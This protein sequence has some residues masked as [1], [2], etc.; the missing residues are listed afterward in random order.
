MHWYS[1]NLN[2][3]RR[4]KLFL[5]QEYSNYSRFYIN[6]ISPS[7]E[8]IN[9][10]EIRVAGL[11]RTGNHAIIGWIRSQHPAKSWHLNHPPAGK[12]PYQYL[13]AHYKKPH[14]RQEAIG[15]FE[16]KSLLIISYEDQPLDQIC[17][18]KFEKFH[19]VYVGL[20]E[21][22]FNVLILRDPFNLL[23]SRLKSK[24]SSLD[25]D[26]AYNALQ[27]W[28]AYAREFLNETQLLK[29][30]KICI[31]Y[32]QW[33]LDKPYRQELAKSMDLVFTD[34]GRERVRGY[35]GGSSFDGRNLDG[36]ASQLDILNRWQAFEDVSQFWQLF[37][38]EE[39]LHYAKS[40]FGTASLPFDRI[41][42]VA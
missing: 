25:D 14:L 7:K 29:G 26:S 3:L 27:L 2:Y 40:I 30:N 4:K 22:C 18:P 12:N 17:S 8:V 16:K 33:H 31:N 1:N 28:K 34:S 39:L 24:M 32:S 6:A 15:K 21:A 9:Q 36:N 41:L 37:R 35:G 13:Y 20:S 42:T 38:D 5:A 10:K 23:A 19:D 11:R